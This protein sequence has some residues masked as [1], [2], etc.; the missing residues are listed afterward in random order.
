MKKVT[1][2]TDG[3][4]KGN[5]GVG[6]WA[7]IVIYKEKLKEIFG[8]EELSTNNRMELLA[9]INGIQL[10]QE[11]C[12]IDIYTDSSYLKN[13]ISIWIKDWQKNDWKN[14]R[15]EE[16]KNKDLWQKLYFLASKHDINWNW[17]KGHCANK[18]NEYVDKLA[19]LAIMQKWEK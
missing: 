11:K 5:P 18:Y 14:K 17:V 2:Y 3:A 19:N 8:Y 1:I 10:L 15:K 12:E 7:A 6:S 13:G 9:A 16:I 4:C